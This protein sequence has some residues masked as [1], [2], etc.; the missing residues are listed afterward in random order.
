MSFA[1]SSRVKLTPR[2]TLHFQGETLFDRI[3][4][5]VCAAECLP[6]KEL[7]E[8]WELARR[9][10]RR[11]RGGRV[12]DAQTGDPVAGAAIVVDGRTAAAAGPDGVFSAPAGPA[13][14]VDVL[15]TAVGYAF[16]TRRVDVTAAGDILVR[17]ASAGTYLTAPDATLTDDISSQGEITLTSTGGSISESF[18]DDGVDL[19]ADRLTLRASTGITG[20]EIAANSLDATTS[21]GDMRKLALM[22]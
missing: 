22:F 21:G 10:R 13:R 7:Y 5:T 16:V 15:V 11:F 14:R 19:V 17:F 9:A 20:L 1:P 8:S 4:R 6:R 18:P 12:L 3:G 2:N